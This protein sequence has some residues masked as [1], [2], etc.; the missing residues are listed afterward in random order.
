MKS[1]DFSGP[2]LPNGAVLLPYDDTVVAVGGSKTLGEYGTQ[3]YK[4]TCPNME[5]PDS[6][7]VWTEQEQKPAGS[8]E[9]CWFGTRCQPTA[10]QRQN[11]QR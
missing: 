8:L 7:C 1:I 6:E 5:Q 9:A 4:L 2:R 10:L 3:I 11:F